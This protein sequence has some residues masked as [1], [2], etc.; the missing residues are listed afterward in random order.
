MA[1]RDR[2][3]RTQRIDG[4]D[5]IEPPISP[6]PPAPDAAGRGRS[7]NGSDGEAP[8]GPPIFGMTE[9][10]FGTTNAGGGTGGMSTVYQ[11]TPS[12]TAP[13]WP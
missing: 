13:Q 1:F 12:A 2:A 7:F 9:A 5:Q 11:L 10:L 3:P 8:N 6:P 4:A